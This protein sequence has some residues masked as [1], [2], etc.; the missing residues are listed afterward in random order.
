[1]LTAEMYMAA[2]EM[3][4]KSRVTHQEMTVCVGSKNH[5]PL[6]LVD[7]PGLIPKCA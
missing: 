2:L 6:T 1:M 7:L 3:L 5:P 4:S